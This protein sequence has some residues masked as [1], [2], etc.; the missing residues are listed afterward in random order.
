VL[1]LQK[2]SSF[3]TTRYGIIMGGNDL[4]QAATFSKLLIC[5]GV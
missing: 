3:K 1:F 4:P 2:N 5:F